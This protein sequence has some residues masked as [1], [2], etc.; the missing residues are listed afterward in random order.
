MTSYIRQTFYQVITIVVLTSTEGRQ[1]VG[2]FELK[3]GLEHG[4]RNS[5]P[6]MT[7]NK[8]QMTLFQTFLILKTVKIGLADSDLVLRI[9][10]SLSECDNL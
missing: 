2:N 7:L 8:N 3:K 10:K 9:V 5:S 1:T 4:S 6:F